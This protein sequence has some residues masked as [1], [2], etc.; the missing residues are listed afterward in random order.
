M[1][2][3]SEM[4]WNYVRL[5]FY[6]RM[7]QLNWAGKAASIFMEMWKS[8]SSSKI[9]SFFLL[10]CWCMT[11]FSSSCACY[12]PRAALDIK[13]NNWQDFKQRISPFPFPFSFSDPLRHFN[14]AVAAAFNVSVFPLFY[15]YFYFDFASGFLHRSPLGKSA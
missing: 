15:F 12:F 13:E 8:F 11:K 10:T 2:N 4:K 5:K 6:G 7:W 3:M 9:P 1:L 14:W